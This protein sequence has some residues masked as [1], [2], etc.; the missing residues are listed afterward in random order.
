M[1]PFILAS[2]SPRRKQ[3]L[4]QIGL[5]FSVLPSDVIEDFS[6]PLPPEAF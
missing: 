3:L 4:E 2:A 5:E 6:L 1:K